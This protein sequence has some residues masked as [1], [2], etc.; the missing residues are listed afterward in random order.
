[1]LIALMVS[2]VCGFKWK[3]YMLYK[4]PL[5]KRS[6]DL[7]WRVLNGALATNMFLSKVDLN[8]G[9]GLHSVTC[10]NLYVFIG[11][12]CVLSLLCFPSAVCGKLGVCT[13]ALWE[14]KRVIIVLFSQAKLTQ[15][16]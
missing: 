16:T 14:D 7:Q 2:E 10:L 3:V 12:H 11:C 6:G 5:P 8:L 1:M 9:K 15:L 13:R 4:L